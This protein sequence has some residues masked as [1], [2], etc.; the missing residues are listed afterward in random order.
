MKKQ[1]AKLFT[2][3]AMSAGILLAS[4]SSS[5][6]NSGVLSELTDVFVEKAQKYMELNEYAQKVADTKDLDEKDKLSQNMIEMNRQ[7]IADEEALAEKAK[8]IGEKLVGTPIEVVASE[9]S[10]LKFSDGVIAEA[11]AGKFANI[12]IKAKSSQPVPNFLKCQLVDDEGNVVDVITSG[13]REDGIAIVIHFAIPHTCTDET[14]KYLQGLGRMTKIV[15]LAGDAAAAPEAEVE[16]EPAFEGS[17]EGDDSESFIYNGV[18]VKVGAPLAETLR[19]LNI[20]NFD[21]NLDYGVTCNIGERTLVI[22]EDDINDKGME[23]IGAIISDMENNIP[24]SIDYIK[25]SAK[26]KEIL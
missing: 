2:L 24:F 7:F 10:S 6:S 8:A 23:V 20:K 26:I 25:P 13:A 5:S 22:E 21:Y 1:F 19:K 11:Y 4:C 18:E 9:G 17:S 15:V 16:P 3:L 12:V 14:V